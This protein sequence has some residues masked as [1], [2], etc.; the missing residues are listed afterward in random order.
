MCIRDRLRIDW[1][2]TPTSEYFYRMALYRIDPSG[3][4]SILTY[5]LN[6]LGGSYTDLDVIDPRNRDYTYYI[7]VENICNEW[8]VQSYI[9]STARESQIP[10]EET[11]LKTATVNVKS[12]EV[13]FLKSKE[14]DFGYYEIYKGT[15]Q[16]GKYKF[17]TKISNI[18]DTVFVDNNVNV[19]TTSY[20]Y[21]VRVVDDCG[22]L[23]SFSNNGCTIV[24]R[25]E[26][27][28]KKSEVPRF[29]FDLR[30][31]DYITWDGG[32]MDYELLRSADTGSLRP[33]VRLADPIVEY[34]DSDLDYD[35]GGYW[36]SVLAYEGPGSQ[37]A[38]SQSNDI[39]LIQPP[40]VFIPNAVTSNGDNLNE[41]FGWSDV[42]VREFEIKVYNRWG[43]KVFQ[44]TDKNANWDGEYKQG[45]FTF[46]NVYFW[47]VRY[48]G[49]D[50]N[51]YVDKGT[52]T[53]VK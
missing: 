32:V 19:N 27:L 22:H 15:R 38:I 3:D 29:K 39:Y 52:L 43:E 5:S 26:A 46:S 7:V 23:S 44:S 25:G 21:Q 24:I 12:I 35:W 33:I 14:D 47:I 30:W 36:Y 2:Q 48:R 31:D 11:Y 17:L 4:T 13:I 6:Q 45:D 37:D 10:V 42:F 16:K 20:C 1:E 51:V 49:W 40:L 8:G 9:L 28:N 34:R 50:N 53:I 18:D 41:V